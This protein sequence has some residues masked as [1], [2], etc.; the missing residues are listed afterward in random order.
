MDLLRAARKRLK[1]TQKQ[2]AARLGVSQPYLSLLE[3]G[4]RKLPPELA[5]K[6]FSA[7][8]L[9]ATALPLLG[10]PVRP[11]ADLGRQLAGLRDEP[12]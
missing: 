6:A 1:L 10:T 2:A 3:K 8:R 9:P 11:R 5:K 4:E 12:Q 7:L